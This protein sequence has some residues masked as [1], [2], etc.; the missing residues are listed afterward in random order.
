VFRGLVIDDNASG[1]ERGPQRQ[2]RYANERCLKALGQTKGELNPLLAVTRDV[3][4]HHHG[5][6]R[7]RLVQSAAIENGPFRLNHGH[8][9]CS[10]SLPPA[11][12]PRGTCGTME[13]AEF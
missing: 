12:A 11:A 5:C 6:E 13:E 7:G 9:R 8:K 1:R 2:A 10:A 4:V 3:D